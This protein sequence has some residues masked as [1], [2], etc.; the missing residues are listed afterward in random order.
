MLYITY[1]L[2]AMPSFERVDTNFLIYLYYLFLVCLLIALTN[3]FHKWAHAYHKLPRIILI[4]QK[5]HIILPR[6]HHHLHHIKPNNK[7][8]CITSGWLNYP[9]ERIGFWNRLENLIFKTT[10]VSPRL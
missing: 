6:A 3:Q 10:G 1:N 7:F 4:L 5:L 8:Y 2:Y 9:L